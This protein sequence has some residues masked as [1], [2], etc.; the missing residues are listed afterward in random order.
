MKK[1]KT[2]KVHGEDFGAPGT[3][4]RKANIKWAAG[5]IIDDLMDHLKWVPSQPPPAPDSGMTDAWTGTDSDKGGIIVVSVV[6]KGD[7]MIGIL[8][9]AGRETTDAAD[10][11]TA[12]LSQEAVHRAYR[13]IER[14]RK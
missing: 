1:R 7:M 14:V 4:K 12:N 10:F 9:E 5:M 2:F 3:A 13:A 8:G 11:K 6:K